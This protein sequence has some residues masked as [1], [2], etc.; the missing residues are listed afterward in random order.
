MK[1]YNTM[2]G[3]KEELI[4]QRDK[5]INM[6]VCG[7][8][9][10]NY[11][12]IGNAMPLIIFDT[13]RRYLKYKGY[14]VKYVQNIT[15][16]DDKIINRMKDENKSYNEVVDFYIKAFKE[17]AKNL[18]VEDPDVEPRVSQEIDEIIK[19][20]QDLIDKGYAYV[21]N[22][23]VYYDIS[24]FKDYGKLSKKNIEDLIEDHRV[25]SINEKRN[26]GDFALWKKMKP[27][28]PYWE[29]PWGKGRPGWH[30]E[31]STMSNKY[32]GKTLDIHAGGIDLVFPHHENEIAQSE[33]RNGVTFSR[34]WMHNAHI[35]MNGEKMS[36][37]LGNIKLVKEVLKEFSGEVV[38]FFFLSKHYRSTID[39][40]YEALVASRSSLER[41]YN[42]LDKIEKKYDVSQEIKIDLLKNFLEKF[43]KALDDDFSTG[44]AIAVIFEAIKYSNEKDEPKVYVESY[45]LIKDIFGKILGLFN[46]K[47]DGGNKELENVMQVLLDV[48]TELRNRKIWDVADK[49]R[50]ELN[51]IGIEIKDSKEGSSWRIRVK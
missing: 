11:I 22:G 36:K 35:N 38:R 29:S 28:E 17:D 24:K 20:V 37:S 27:G 3:K 31:C 39:Y 51:K 49:I 7:P 6:Y 46:K 48:R 21:V 13:F 19:F 47:K 18:G 5:E 40:S 25:S 12:H 23:D 4:P 50:D 41:I 45:H 10:Y 42:Y 43:E 34:Y 9:V 1:I 33:A 2:S 44:R 32:L 26:P 14:K 8:T 15:D 30:I 16:V